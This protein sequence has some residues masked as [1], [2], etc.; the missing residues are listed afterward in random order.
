MP[1]TIRVASEMAGSDDEVL[2]GEFDDDVADVGDAADEDEEE[3]AAKSQLKG[4][5][6][7]KAA[8]DD[9]SKMRNNA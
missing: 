3:P 4:Q 6:K 2:P 1:F 5:A 7:G 8:K 9:Q